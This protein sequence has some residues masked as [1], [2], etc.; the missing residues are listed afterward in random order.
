[1]SAIFDPKLDP[2]LHATV[3]YCS[4]AVRV[5]LDAAA[6][7]THNESDAQVHALAI[8]GTVIELFSACVG[9][10]SLGEPTGVPIILRSMYEAHIDLDNL[11]H[12]A[13]YVEHIQAAGYE[14]TIRIMEAAPLRQVLNEGRKADYEELSARAADLK[15]RG[16]GPLK[17]WKRCQ[18][19]GRLDEYNGLYALFCMDTHSNS[20]ALGERHVGEKA[21]GGLVISIFGPYDPWTVIRRL[22]LGL[23]FL[24]RSARDAHGAFKVPAPQIDELAARLEKVKAERAKRHPNK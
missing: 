2:E 23:E 20:P 15:C 5:V 13:G 18:L 6:K 1:M 9:L 24:F 19:A 4:Q 12:D 11:T 10:A 7:L 17:I 21:D 3:E 8:Y 14:Q 22:D 16:K